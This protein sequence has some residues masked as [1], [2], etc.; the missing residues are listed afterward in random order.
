MP[1]A[2]VIFDTRTRIVYQA[3]VQYRRSHSKLVNVETVVSKA[4]KRHVRSTRCSA[5]QA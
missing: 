1:V 2:S 3:L 4:R 5:L